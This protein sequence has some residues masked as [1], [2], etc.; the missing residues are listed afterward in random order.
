LNWGL[1]F[2]IGPGRPIATSAQPWAGRRVLGATRASH[3]PIT[4]RRDPMAPPVSLDTP[5]TY[6]H[7][8]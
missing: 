6:A 7:T 1:F 8:L 2:V 5:R 3:A 4:R